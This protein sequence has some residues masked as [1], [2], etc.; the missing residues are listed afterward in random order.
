MFVNNT[1]SHQLLNS[2]EIF[3]NETKKSICSN[4]V[5]YPR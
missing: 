5:E 1:I 4:N 2:F 3:V